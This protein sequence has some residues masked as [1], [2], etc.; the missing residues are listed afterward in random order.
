MS[1]EPS[2]VKFLRLLVQH[3]MTAA[4]LADQVWGTPACDGMG[5]IN[6]RDGREEAEC[7]ECDGEGRVES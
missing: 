6:P 2:S 4:Q 1:K 3:E 7:H 5:Y